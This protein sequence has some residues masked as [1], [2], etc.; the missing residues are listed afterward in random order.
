MNEVT[1]LLYEANLWGAEFRELDVVM[2]SFRTTVYIE[3]SS[4]VSS[5]TTLRETCFP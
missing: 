4:N 2:L 1:K 3:F 5:K